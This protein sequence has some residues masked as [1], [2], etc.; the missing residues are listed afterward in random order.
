M[1]YVLDEDLKL[2]PEGELGALYV[3]GYNLASGYVGIPNSE[4]FITNPYSNTWG[5]GPIVISI[6]LENFLS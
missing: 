5:T 2:K 4:K 3:A 6:K 1:L